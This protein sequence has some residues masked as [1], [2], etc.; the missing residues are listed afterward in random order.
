MNFLQLDGEEAAVKGQWGSLA[1]TLFQNDIGPPNILTF[2]H[3]ML[4]YITSWMQQKLELTKRIWQGD[5]F[6]KFI[7]VKHGFYNEGKTEKN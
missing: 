6:L 5:N 4:H 7:K 3:I 2:W 1:S